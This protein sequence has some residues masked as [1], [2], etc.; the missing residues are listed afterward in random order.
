MKSLHDVL[1]YGLLLTVANA[2]T[3]TVLAEAVDKEK[4]ERDAKIRIENFS[5]PPGLEVKLWAD[6]S[7]TQNPSAITFD[8]LGRMLVCEINRWRNGVDDIR[9]RKFML[10]D[11]LFIQ[12]SDD[13]L[14][15]FKKHSHRIPMS[16]YTAKQDQIRLL[17]DRDGDGRADRATIYAD[18]FND[19]LDGPGIGVITRDND[20]YYTNIPHLW[21][22]EDLDGDSK[23]DK[24]TSLQDGFGIRMSF[25]GHDMHGLAW[26]PEGKL[27][28]SLGDRGYSFT[29]KEGVRFHGPNEGAVFR[30]DPDGANIELFY[31][32]L[33][34]PQELAFD[35]YGNL[36]TADNDA[37]GEDVE[38]INYL[39]EGGD[40][41]W[42]AGF[43]AIKSF[44]SD[45]ELRSSAYLNERKIPNPWMAEKM[46]SVRTNEQPAFILPGIGQIIGG[47]SGLVYN[48][49][50]SMGEKYDD[51]FF[52]IHYKG[53]PSASYISSFGVEENG[54]GFNMV[55]YSE[56]FRGSNSV[57]I[58][59][60]PD[61]K[62]YMSE[63]NYG[64]WTN[65]DVGNIYTFSFPKELSKPTV[66]QNEKRLRSDFSK[67]SVKELVSLLAVDHLTVRQR[68][69]FEL[70]KRGSAAE[71]AFLNAAGN[72]RND[73]FTRIHGVWGLGMMA[74]NNPSLLDSIATLLKDKNDQVRIQSARVLGDHRWRA[75]TL[76]LV[77]A[78]RDS[79]PR[80]AMYAGIALGRMQYAGAVDELVAVLRDNKGKDLWLRHGAIMGLAGVSDKKHYLKYAKDPSS[81]VR[82]GILLTLRRSKD[83]LIANFLDDS[84]QRIVY[85]AIRAI[86]DL[87]I[88]EGLAKLAAKLDHFPAPKISSRVDKLMHHRLIN[89][90]YY[91]AKTDSA[92]RLL[93]YAKRKDIP[94]RQKREAIAA[95]EAWNDKHKLD[96]IT[97]LPRAIAQPR[98]DISKEIKKG[99][100]SVFDVAD[101][102]LLAQTLRLGEQYSYRF[103][104][105]KLV[106]IA[107]DIKRTVSARVAAL[108]YL[109]KHQYTKLDQL[110]Q[111]DILN[112]KSAEIR[113]TALKHL[114]N[115]NPEKAIVA[116][117]ALTQIGPIID[118]Q[119]A[120]SVI[121]GQDTGP[122]IKRLKQDMHNVLD[123][124][125]QPGI[126]LEILNA[127]Q[128]S[129][130]PEL[131]QL[132]SQ[133]QRQIKTKDILAQYKPSMEGGSVENGKDL[134]FNHGASQCMRCHKIRGRG[135]DVG[136]D[137]SRIGQ[138]STAYLL[139]AIV[140]PGA[141]VAQGYGYVALTL[142]DGSAV[143]GVYMGES[144]GDYQVKLPD[145]KVV[146]IAAK[147]IAQVQPPMS[148]MPPMTSLMSPAQ[149][150][151]VVAYLSSLK[152]R[153]K[154]SDKKANSH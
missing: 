83:P 134:F 63:Y 92:Q 105:A 32:R 84:D 71:K 99:I 142:K 133:Y 72:I 50:D 33:R 67:K 42:H 59:F 68:A 139:Q 12:S 24:R 40:S 138:K 58:E 110:L 145:K 86:N 112:D 69:Q 37:D 6:S 8:P 25:S 135:A 85:E 49:S 36:F 144:N 74:R 7:Q 9:E 30:S 29:S 17:E 75:A 88:N 152:P 109:S 103:D 147:N 4:L 141:K 2:L 43:Q 107:G 15:M 55:E 39:V 62:M 19:P 93:S 131:K 77:E 108:N 123:E 143:N 90:N 149:I 140:D 89:A 127:V 118:R 151:D 57:D 97:G 102:R 137:L 148:G 101:G 111:G 120:Y 153:K 150:R 79:H 125:A 10:W 60:G 21:K 23:A 45:Y 115:I 14:A 31:D 129:N 48:P 5:K 126:T 132:L 1:Q 121:S 76:V 38:R 28:W 34:N 117:V 3:G 114:L 27:Y 100:G 128:K 124:S 98:A 54:A 106:R 96:T 56:F 22:L 18:G 53:S 51:K 13:R 41:G 78:L 104:T 119:K 113:A 20:V 87:P 66:K 116:A 70:A 26:G 64:G 82:M 44:A 95:L 130:N 65:Q 52:V 146:T 94:E 122:V 136:P 81:Y 154:S 47:P 73:K 91:Q 46:W 35:D 80:V 11:D 61:G 16:H